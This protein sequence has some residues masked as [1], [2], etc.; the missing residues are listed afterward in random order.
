LIQFR[1]AKSHPAMLDAKLKSPP[2]ATPLQ[3]AVVGGVQLELWLLFG[4]V[5][6]VLLIACA[7]LA[8]LLLARA[9]ARSIEFA[10]RSALGASRAR[11]VRHLLFESVLLSVLG[12]MAGAF[13]AFLSLSGIR[14]IAGTDLPRSG[15]IQFDGAV[16]IFAIALSF[17]TAFLFGLAPSLSAARRD[18]MTV[19]RGSSANS[20]RFRLRGILVAGQIAF[21]M[22]LLIGA[23]LLLESILHLRAEV[24]GFDSQNLLTARIALPSNADPVSFFDDLLGRIVSSPGVEHASA[25][26]TLPMTSYP[27]TPVQDA[28]QP[29]LP[30]N[31]RS[32]AAMFIVTP[33]YFQ[34]LRIPLRRG[35]AFTAHDREGTARV[36]VID[37]GLARHLWPGYPAGQNPVG[38]RILVGGINKTPAEVVGIVADVHQDIENAGWGRGVYVPFA[39]LPTPAAMLAIRVKENPLGFSGTLRRAVQSLNP[40]FPISDVERMRDLVDSQLGGRRVLVQVLAF[41]A[42]V[43]FALALVGI[44]GLISHS[45][46]QRTREMGVRKAL[47]ASQRSIVQMILTQTLRL[48]LIGVILGAAAALAGTRLLKSY[49]FHIGATDPATFVGV[50]VLFIAVAGGAALAPAFRAANVEPI[51]ALHYE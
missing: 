10:V 12:G 17:L 24:L 5:L 49:L 28:S 48:T 31:Q 11:I 37:E 29:A 23:T 16:L 6:L 19:L 47:G 1:Y 18:L 4:A 2:V 50:A 36:A 20:S 44:Y 7:N 3:R 27:G 15:E 51:Q 30:L 35:R 41:F 13:L 32:L 25:S 22:L 8:S 14:R 45:V 42:A 34:T 43:A 9:S 40:A 26:L 33:D 21:S 46:A 38:Q 39:Q